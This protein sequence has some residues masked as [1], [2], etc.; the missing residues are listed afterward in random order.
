[1][2]ERE[3]MV[4]FVKRLNDKALNRAITKAHASEVFLRNIFNEPKPEGGITQEQA[5]AVLI[6]NRKNTI[7]RIAMVRAF[8]N[9][10]VKHVKAREFAAARKYC[11]LFSDMNN[12]IYRAYI[13]KDQIC[14]SA[15]FHLF[16]LRT[17]AM[18][19]HFV[20]L[21]K[22]CRWVRPPIAEGLENFQFV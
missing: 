1:M 15:E 16:I 3:N 22:T 17:L 12:I 20:K 21:A 10:L 4:K 9:K 8:Y 7:V 6:A 5:R 14:P 19:R 2:R 11:T 18:N 13:E